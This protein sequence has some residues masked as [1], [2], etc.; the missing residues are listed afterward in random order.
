MN[1]FEARCFCCV[2]EVV[3]MLTS[4]HLNDKSKEVCV[5]A[6]S[7]SASL[8]FSGQVTKHTIVKWSVAGYSYKLSFVLYRWFKEDIN[9]YTGQMDWLFT[10]NYWNR[11]WKICP[12]IF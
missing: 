2:N 5:K 3:V 10:G 7:P 6:R 12:D 8:A 1:F 11:D 9:P 4:L